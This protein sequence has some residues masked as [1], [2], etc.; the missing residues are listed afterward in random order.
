MDQLSGWRV[1]AKLEKKRLLLAVNSIAALS[2]FFFGYDQGM[3][4]GVNN[5]Q[6][7]ISLMK[8]GYTSADGDPVVTDSLLQGGIVSVYYLGTLFG[9]LMGGWT[10]DKVGRIKT[11][12]FGALWAILGASL[13]CS[14]QNANWMICARAVNGLGTGVLNAIVPVWAT[15]T[16]EATSRGQFIAVEF[17][18]NIFGVVVAY[19]LEFGLSFVDG[20]R[21]P[22]RWRFPIA[23]QILPLLV[24]ISAVWFFPESPRW[25]CKVGREKEARYILGRLRGEDAEGAAL[26]DAEFND[27]KNIVIHERKTANRNS[28]FSMLFGIGAGKLHTARRVQLVVW[29]QI[30]QEWIGIAGVTI[31]APTIFRIAGF[32]SEKSQWISGLNNIFY[33]FSTLICVFTLDRIGRRW[34]LYWGSVGMGIAMF[35]AGGMARGGLNAR[36]AGDEAAAG[37][38][39]I[40]SASFVFIFTFIF[41]ATW[42]TV[43]W[44]YPAEIFPLEVRAKGNAWGVVGWSIGNGWLTLLC[45]VMFSAIGEKTLYIFGACNVI[46]IP[47]VW[48]LY[49]ETNQRTLEE[50]DLVFA[51][52]TPWVWDAERNFRRLKAENPGLVMAASR[53][54]SVVDPEVGVV[55]EVRED[56]GE[57][58][59]M[60]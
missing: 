47:M 34:T 38:Y 43:P 4:G 18:L 24:L 57:V 15:E 33:M 45:P 55:E 3:M 7:Y 29:L 54:N 52:D 58:P 21:S 17:T 16:A 56:R 32:S 6:N 10:G 23:F 41:G 37:A 30:M 2:I 26:A 50:M 59:K 40:A 27:I 1:A 12:A 22:V 11:I 46:T 48:A 36:A 53:G 9:C 49:P 19:W 13:Q 42:L 14:A 44:L 39:G 20:G 35:L 5:A 28:Y 51:A 8:F 25:L 31:Y 60:E